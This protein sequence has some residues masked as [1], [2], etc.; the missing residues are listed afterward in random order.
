[1]KIILN[2]VVQLTFCPFLNLFSILRILLSNLILIVW[3]IILNLPIYLICFLFLIFFRIL[4]FKSLFFVWFLLRCCKNLLNIL[5]LSIIIGYIFNSWF[6]LGI[7]A[8]KDFHQVRI[9]NLCPTKIAF[10]HFFSVMLYPPK[11]IFKK[12]SY[13][14]R[15]ISF[16]NKILVIDIWWRVLKLYH[17]AGLLILYQSS[18]IVLFRFFLNFK[19]F[20]SWSIVLVTRRVNCFPIKLLIVV[21][22]TII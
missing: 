21:N 16:S 17:N 10:F 20:R 2:F 4:R 13:H 15:I 3:L 11:S 22:W 9:F 7:F 6:N 8:R 1:M 12:R 18:N 19:I 14:Y 5:C